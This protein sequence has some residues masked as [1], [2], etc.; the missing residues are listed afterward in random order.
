MGKVKLCFNF[1]RLLRKVYRG[2]AALLM[3]VAVN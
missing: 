2:V 3:K 1:A